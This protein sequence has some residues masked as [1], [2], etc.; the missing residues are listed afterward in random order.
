[1]LGDVVVMAGLLDVVGL[2][3]G[4]C[5]LWSVASLL[6]VRCFRLYMLGWGLEKS[7]VLFMILIEDTICLSSV[8]GECDITSI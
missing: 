5:S 4:S 7:V 2:G 8:H 6:F 1:M 3:L